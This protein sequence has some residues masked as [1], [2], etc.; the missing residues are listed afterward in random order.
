[1]PQPKTVEEGYH[2]D[3][4][5]ADH[6]I[7]FILDAK[8]NAP[9]KPFFLYYAPGCAHAPHQVAK[10][11]IDKYKG[12]FDMGWDKYREVVFQRQKEMGLFP[13]DAELSSRDP[14]V[15]EWDTLT[16]QQKQLYARFMEVY[17]GFLEHCDSQ[18][19]RVLQALEDIGETTGPALRAGS[20]AHSTR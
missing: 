5:L 8:V 16:D 9:D 20:M 17:A 11:W 1:V 19:G 3:E 4:D 6:A 12:V 18:I 7:Q 2:L 15:P 13:A 10:E 14:D